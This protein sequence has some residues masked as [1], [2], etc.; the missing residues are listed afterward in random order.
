MS[1][2]DIG[3]DSTPDDPDLPAGPRLPNDPIQQHP[4][5]QALINLEGHV[6]L[7][8]LFDGT[9]DAITSPG[10]GDHQAPA[11]ESRIENA[12]D[13]FDGLSSFLRSYMDHNADNASDSGTTDASIPAFASNVCLKFR[14]DILTNHWLKR[15]T[16]GY[17]ATDIALFFAKLEVRALFTCHYVSN[18]TLSNFRS[19]KIWYRYVF[20][21]SI[22]SLLL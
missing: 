6:D 1:N 2:F 4:V 12:D 8:P 20:R 21:C 3:T 14:S 7:L 10:L 15:K 16:I 18:I 22:S 11:S 13:G 9:Q 19:S 17:I 5:A